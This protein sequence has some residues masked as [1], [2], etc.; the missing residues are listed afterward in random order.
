MLNE[1]NSSDKFTTI[2]FRFNTSLKEDEHYM[3]CTRAK[4]VFSMGERRGFKCQNEIDLLRRRSYQFHIRTA[5]PE[6][7]L[8]LYL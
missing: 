3:P 5:C 1:V 6:C 2:V 7:I 8:Y 4:F